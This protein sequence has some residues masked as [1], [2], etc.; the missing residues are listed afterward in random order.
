MRSWVSLG[1]AASMLYAAYGLLRDSGRILLGAAPPRVSVTEI[2][3]AM[4]KDP[5]GL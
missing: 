1:I 2:G 4:L 3:R 5:R